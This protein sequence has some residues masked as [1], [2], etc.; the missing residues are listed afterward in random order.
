MNEY[1]GKYK[2]INRMETETGFNYVIG[3]NLNA[4]QGYQYVTW[5]Q[6]ERGYDSGHY[7]GNLKNAQIDLLERSAKEMDVNLESH[8]FKKFAMEDIKSALYSI[9]SPKIAGELFKDKDL[10]DSLYHDYMKSDISIVQQLEVL[11]IGSLKKIEIEKGQILQNYDSIDSFGEILHSLWKSAWFYPEHECW[12]INLDNLKTEEYKGYFT[13]EDI[14]RFYE[15][16]EVL[17]LLYGEEID[18]IFDYFT[19]IE[20]YFVQQ[21]PYGDTFLV[22]ATRNFIGIFDENGYMDDEIIP[23]EICVKNFVEEFE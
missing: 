22:K 14:Q 18:D 23:Y 17:K 13:R 9:S 21:P 7:F 4:L 2:I 10:M 15:D 1:N 16:I 11:I 6:N 20:E 3:E 19:D 12:Y 8:Y 5:I